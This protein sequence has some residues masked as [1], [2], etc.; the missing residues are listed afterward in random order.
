MK[1]NVTLINK[2]EW[3]FQKRRWVLIREE[4]VKEKGYG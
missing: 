1:E 2:R 4:G 3:G